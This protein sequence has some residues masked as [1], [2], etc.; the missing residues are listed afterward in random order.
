MPEEKKVHE[1]KVHPPAARDM[2]T[3][4]DG[5]AALRELVGI[6]HEGWVVHQQESSKRAR[7]RTYEQTEVAKIHAAER[8]LT[9]YFDQV[10]AERR[11]LYVDMF[12]RLD[13]AIEKDQPEIANAVVRGIVDVAQSSPIAAGDLGQIRAALDNPNHEWEL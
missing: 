5:L 10:F 3:D 12:A 4:A 8:A 7:L 9:R 2:L 1:G 11:S 6:V 13:E